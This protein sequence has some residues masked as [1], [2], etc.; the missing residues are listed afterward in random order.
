MLVKENKF[1]LTRFWSRVEAYKFPADYAYDEKW[2]ATD[3]GTSSF[4]RNR[5][6][7]S[8]LCRLPE[9]TALIWAGWLSIV[10][11]VSAPPSKNSPA[12]STLLLSTQTS[13]VSFSRTTRCCTPD[14]VTVHVFRIWSRDRWVYIDNIYY[15]V[16]MMLI[17]RYACLTS[18]CIRLPWLVVRWM[19][20]TPSH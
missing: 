19:F 2:F 1:V 18:Y 12:V 4:S 13:S 20:Y 15:V 17:L 3:A 8:P 5:L 6:W 14:M 10:K 11:C 9:L 16:S 7:I